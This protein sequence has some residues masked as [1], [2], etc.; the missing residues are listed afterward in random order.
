MPCTGDHGD[1]DLRMVLDKACA[2][3]R[4][5]PLVVFGHMHHTLYHK[6]G[7]RQMVHIE[8]SGT[9]LLNCAVVP[10]CALEPLHGGTD[11]VRLHQFTT[12]EL[13]EGIVHSVS[14]VWVGVRGAECWIADSKQIV[15]T[16]SISSDRVV[17]SFLV[18]DQSGNQAG[19]P[20][21]RWPEKELWFTAVHAGK[22][23]PLM[24]VK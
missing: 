8:D 19:M 15:K 10:R 3:A 6:S 1:P 21:R 5:V 12:V 4:P 23:S 13:V 17:R 2:A 20:C 16:E 18:P 7:F 9:V 14:Q 24:T 11:K 22:T